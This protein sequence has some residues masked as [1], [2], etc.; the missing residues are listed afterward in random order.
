MSLLWKTASQV[1]PAN[2]VDCPICEDSYDTQKEADACEKRH[3][4]EGG[5]V[6]LPG[7]GY[8]HNEDLPPSD[9]PNDYADRESWESRHAR[10]DQG[11]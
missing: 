11:S 4:T 7:G 5:M 3:F 1:D 6:R 10:R 8:A 9:D 2:W